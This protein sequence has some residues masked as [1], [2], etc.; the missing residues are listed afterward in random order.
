MDVNNR[1]LFFI[2]IY[3]IVSAT[4]SIFKKDTLNAFLSKLSIGF[5]MVLIAKCF[6]L[7]Q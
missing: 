5:L 4:I 7:L 6:S 2:L 1:I 3:V